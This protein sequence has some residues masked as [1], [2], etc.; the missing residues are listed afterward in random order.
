MIFTFIF[1]L[2]SKLFWLHIWLYIETQKLFA[3]KFKK[4]WEENSRSYVSPVDGDEVQVVGGGV[5]QGTL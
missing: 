1:Y 3:I 4:V 5:S 2:Q